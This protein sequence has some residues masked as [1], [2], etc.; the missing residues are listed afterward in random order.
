MR[1]TQVMTTHAFYKPNKKLQNQHPQK[2]AYELH[3]KNI[4]FQFDLCVRIF[5]FQKQVTYLN[6]DV[7]QTRLIGVR[8]ELPK[9]V[10]L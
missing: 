9:L 2:Y 7:I 10:P 8:V 3:K 6:P 1:Y 4:H 5:F